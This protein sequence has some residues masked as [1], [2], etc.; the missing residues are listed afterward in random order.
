VG[1]VNPIVQAAYGIWEIV[2]QGE[3]AFGSM[4]YHREGQQHKAGGLFKWA[5]QHEAT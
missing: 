4:H 3:Q 2:E 5:S 1:I